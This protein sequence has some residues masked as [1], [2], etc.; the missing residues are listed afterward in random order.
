VFSTGSQ[1]LQFWNANLPGG[2]CLMH[3]MNKLALLVQQNPKCCL[4]LIHA[5]TYSSTMQKIAERS[6]AITTRRRAGGSWVRVA[7]SGMLAWWKGLAAAARTARAT[8]DEERGPLS[9]YDWEMRRM[10]R[11]WRREGKTSAVRSRSWL[12]FGFLDW[13]QGPTWTAESPLG[14]RLELITKIINKWI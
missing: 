6:N 14:P 9:A 5:W 8:R 10:R 2:A 7:A 13:A 12:P 3:R 11:W 1:Q 4:L